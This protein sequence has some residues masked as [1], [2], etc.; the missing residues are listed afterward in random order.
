[1]A[2]ASVQWDLHSPSAPPAARA[3]FASQVSSPVGLQR[4]I[5][6]RSALHSAAFNLSHN[7][8]ADVEALM[9]VFAAT[10]KLSFGPG[11]KGFSA[12]RAQYLVAIDRGDLL[13]APAS[14]DPTAVTS[15]SARG[16]ADVPGQP[17]SVGLGAGLG[18]AAFFALLLAGVL[19]FRC[20]ERGAS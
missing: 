12:L 8:E 2:S 18:V 5:N 9:S 15:L 16:S 3:P 7:A 10:L 1:M 4:F 11:G 6:Y 14:A 19:V 20:A 13:G 17:A